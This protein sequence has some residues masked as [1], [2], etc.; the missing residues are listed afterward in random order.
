MK[1]KGVQTEYLT[2]RLI[3]LV[4]SVIVVVVHGIHANREW[5]R[6]SL[7]VGLF[8]GFTV[9]QQVAKSSREGLEKLGIGGGEVVCPI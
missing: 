1:R 9:R 4:A 2:G 3:T 8:S 6:S 5:F 7:E